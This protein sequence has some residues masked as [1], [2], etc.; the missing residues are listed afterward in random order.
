MKFKLWER[1]KQYRARKLEAEKTALE[2]KRKKRRA[3]AHMEYEPIVDGFLSEY[4]EKL[5]KLSITLDKFEVVIDS[6]GHERIYF[7][8]LN[9]KSRFPKLQK[10]LEFELLP[11]D[12]EEI[13]KVIEAKLHFEF[14]L[15]KQIQE[16]QNDNKISG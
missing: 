13:M 7:K 12:N 2:K 16:A 15:T 14:C 1:F 10:Y 6:N 9:E 8:F 4:G 3:A 5:K 11:H